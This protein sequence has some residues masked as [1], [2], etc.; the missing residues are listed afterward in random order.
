MHGCKVH[1]GVCAAGAGARRR[2]THDDH[3]SDE[4][5]DRAKHCRADYNSRA[6]RDYS[7]PDTSTSHANTSANDNDNNTSTNTST[8]TS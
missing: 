1:G 7:Y 3:T 8:C 5:T 6:S 2:L 4:C